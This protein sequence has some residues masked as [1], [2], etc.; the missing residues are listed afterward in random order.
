M[1]YRETFE[2]ADATERLI[3]SVGRR[4]AREDPIDLSN[5][6]RLDAACEQAWRDAVDGL[7]SLH[8]TDAQ[9]GAAIGPGVTKQAVAARWPRPRPVTDKAGLSAD[10]EGG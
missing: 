7:R 1:T 6:Q 8:Y 5:L 3:R 9:I 2:V 4:V 10:G